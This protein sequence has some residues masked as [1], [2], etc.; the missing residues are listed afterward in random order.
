MKIHSLFRD[1]SVFFHKNN[2]QPVD[3][4]ELATSITT[5]A[6]WGNNDVRKWARDIFKNA[7]ESS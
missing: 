2:K 1:T 3:I 7:E 5:S 6:E 4:E